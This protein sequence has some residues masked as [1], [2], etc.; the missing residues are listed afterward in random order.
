[1]SRQFTVVGEHR[2]EPTYLLIVGD[3]G[4]YYAYFP[5]RNEFSRVK[6]DHQ[7]RLYEQHQQRVV[8]IDSDGQAS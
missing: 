3:D 6:L 2:Y 8:T 5:K 4:R 7:W 1:M